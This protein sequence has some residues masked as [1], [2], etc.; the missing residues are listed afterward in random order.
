MSKEKFLLLLFAFAI[1]IISK[2]QNFNY[3]FS[4]SEVTYL[5]LIDSTSTVIDSTVWDDNIYKLPIGFTFRFAGQD[6]DT[7]RI[8]TNGVFT[9]DTL[10]RYNFVALYKNFICETD[11]NN[12]SQSPILKEVTTNTNGKKTLKIEFRNAYLNV[13]SSKKHINFQVWLNEENNSI[14]FRIGNFDGGLA[15]E[16]FLLGLMD[17]DGKGE[18]NTIAFLVN[19]GSGSSLSSSSVDKGQSATHLQGLMSTGTSVIFIPN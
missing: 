16:N 9:F 13:G 8:R 5:P 14:E 17:M 1:T 11:I 12:K 15:S 7:V 4:A 2:S 19:N 3:Q 18:N 6:F 10:N